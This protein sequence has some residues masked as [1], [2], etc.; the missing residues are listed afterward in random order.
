MLAC[1]WFL[2]N[3]RISLAAYCHARYISTCCTPSEILSSSRCVNPMSLLQLGNSVVILVKKKTSGIQSRSQL[4]TAIL[5]NLIRQVIRNVSSS[6][7]QNSLPIS[8]LL[9]SFFSFSGLAHGLTHSE[10]C[11][12]FSLVT[13]LQSQSYSIPCSLWSWGSIDPSEISWVHRQSVIINTPN[14]GDID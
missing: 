8:L 1:W 2:H 7:R 11:H 10:S 4:V 12:T 5:L 6:L 13:V 14:I 9:G 3:N